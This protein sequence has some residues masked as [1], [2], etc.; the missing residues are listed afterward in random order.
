MASLSQVRENALGLLGAI[1]IGGSVSTADDNR[2]SVAYSKVYAEMKDSGLAVWVDT[3]AVP[4]KITMHIEALM[5]YEAMDEYNVSDRIYARVTA[6]EA[7]ARREIRRLVQPDY[8]S[9]EQ[10]VDY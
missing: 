7:K 10:P 5:A 4:D 2:M 3:D 8:E 6:K 9:T 1:D